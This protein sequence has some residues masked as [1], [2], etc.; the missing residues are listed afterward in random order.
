MSSM[1]GGVE[2]SVA[3]ALLDGIARRDG[4]AIAACLTRDAKLRALTPH[5]LREENGSDAIV[6]RYADWLDPLE[7][8]ELLA[9]DAEVVV[10]RIRIRYRFRGRDPKHG[11]QENEHTAY[12]EMRGLL[13]AA[14]NL[15]CAGFRA[16][17]APPGAT[18]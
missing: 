16:R 6:A 2:L 4:A 13:I 12:A 18:G 10:D 9:A 1:I 17:S 14:L 5:Q 3:R 15:S 11:W 8:F 7:D